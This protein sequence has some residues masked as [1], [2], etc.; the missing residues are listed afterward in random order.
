MKNEITIPILVSDLKEK[1]FITAA[2]HRKK[3]SQK[4]DIQAEDFNRAIITRLAKDREKLEQIQSEVG[5]QVACKKCGKKF[6][7]GKTTNDILTCPDCLQ[8]TIIE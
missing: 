5:N 3:Y 6:S 2:E 7:A 8:N 1:D 4:R